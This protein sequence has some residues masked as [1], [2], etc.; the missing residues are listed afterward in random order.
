VN[1][2]V[3]SGYDNYHAR[4]QHI[5][6][7]AH[8]VKL[9]KSLPAGD[10]SMYIW[11]NIY[12]C[13]SVGLSTAATAALPAATIYVSSA[14]ARCD[15]RFLPFP[16]SPGHRRIYMIY[17]ILLLLLFVKVDDASSRLNRI[18]KQFRAHLTGATIIL[19]AHTITSYIYIY[20]HV[21]Q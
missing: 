13:P 11:V 21:E 10:P 2:V 12:L 15:W 3:S 5:C 6:Q 7:S 8:N 19:Y 18:L 4:S 14:S 16:P 20:I 1:F 17:R 9:Y